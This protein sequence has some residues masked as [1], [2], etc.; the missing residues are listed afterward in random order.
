MSIKA[1][2]FKIGRRVWGDTN[3]QAEMSMLESS[4]LE[5]DMVVDSGQAPMANNS[6]ESTKMTRETGMDFI[7]GQ[8]ATSMRDNSRTISEMDW[9]A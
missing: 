2:I 5:K 9:D 8:M 6:K 7:D 4:R 3:G 1:I